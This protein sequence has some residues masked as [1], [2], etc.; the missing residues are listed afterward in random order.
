MNPSLLRALIT[1]PLLLLAACDRPPEEPGA[2]TEEV[3]AV[4]HQ[5]IENMV[6]IDGGTFMLGDGGAES[7]LPWTAHRDN[8]S[9]PVK[10]T[11]DSYSI[12]RYETTWGEFLVY[13]RHVE[14]S[15]RYT[16]EGGFGLARS[17]PIDSNHDPL[18]PNYHRKP[19]RSPNYK[20]AEGYCQWLA[21]HSGLPVSLPSEAQWEFAA[22]NRGENI[23]YATDTG[24]ADRDPYL[25]G[26][27]ED[28]DPAVPPSG[29][30]L[31]AS[32]LVWERRPVGT[33]PPNPLGL[34]DMTGNVSEWTRDWYQKDFYQH[35]PRNNPEGPD[36]PPDPED[37]RKVV[38]DLG[39]MGS[40]ILGSETVFA[41]TG[42]YLDAPIHGFRCVVNAEQPVSG[43]HQP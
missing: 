27:I 5:A 39:G 7:G 35:A 22:R 28:I 14:R 33:Y 16:V 19:A 25:R 1:T 3:E 4:V 15:Q 8:N 24:E 20:E 23:P 32:S 42:A 29:N 34:H 30:L 21:E 26:R 40:A 12:G 38:R 18:S 43:N 13:L 6:F 11:L 9:P 2:T 17:Y 37:P 10:V 41:R 36:A 31:L